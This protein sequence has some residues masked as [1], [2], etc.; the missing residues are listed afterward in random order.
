LQYLHSGDCSFPREQKSAQVVAGLIE[1]ATKA[2]REQ[3][4]AE[5]QRADELEKFVE[6]ADSV[7]EYL[8]A[9]LGYAYDRY[10]CWG[11]PALN[12]LKW[13]KELVAKLAD[14][15]MNCPSCGRHDYGLIAGF[16]AEDRTYK[17]RLEETEK[18]LV[19]SEARCQQFERESHESFS[20]SNQHFKRAE[21]AEA[22]RDHFQREYR[23]R[24]EQ[25]LRDLEKLEKCEAALSAV[26]AVYGTTPEE[27]T[28]ANNL[29]VADYV[30]SSREALATQRDDAL[31]ALSEARE[32]IDLVLSLGCVSP[33]VRKALRRSL[34]H[35]APA[36]YT[37][38]EQ[39]KRD[40]ESLE[41][42]N[43]RLDK[44]EELR[45]RLTEKYAPAKDE[46]KQEPA[47]KVCETCRGMCQREGPGRCCYTGKPC[48]HCPDCKGT[49]RAKACEVCKRDD[50]QHKFSCPVGGVRSTQPVLGATLLGAKESTE[51]EQAGSVNLP[52]S[53]SDTGE[54]GSSPSSYE[55][56]PDYAMARDAK[57]AHD[58]ELQRVCEPCGHREAAADTVTVSRERWEAL[59]RI[60]RNC[61]AWPC[62]P[63][64][65]MG[66]K[67]R[68]RVCQAKYYFEAA[69]SEAARNG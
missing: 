46:A 66:D 27:I 69:E 29:T 47:S 6:G 45:E 54:A 11:E 14:A 21:K 31:A 5:K 44:S 51:S 48:P 59:E 52:P 32:S 43:A 55:I 3:L 67:R 63:L 49:G 33:G 10:V 57:H 26:A 7:G 8:A 2:L 58:F 36:P 53:P 50:G 16:I 65:H 19:A 13:A 15:A 23:E 39:Q 64:G 25:H 20:K 38:S 40:R 56:G 12:A 4:A 28:S 41:K 24:S 9:Q 42:A 18:K 17:A 30:K 61:L 68:C 34:A 37:G 22:A 35:T 1:S 62:D 60:A